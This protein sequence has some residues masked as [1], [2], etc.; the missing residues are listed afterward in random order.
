M[1]EPVVQCIQN[2]ETVM[3]KFAASGVSFNMQHWLQRFAFDC[4][5]IITVST[6]YENCIC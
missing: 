5:S 4:I 6:K 3:D 2:L 1:E